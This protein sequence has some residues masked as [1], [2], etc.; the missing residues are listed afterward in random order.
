L[1]QQTKDIAFIVLISNIIFMLFYIML[2]VFM[3]IADMYMTFDFSFNIKTMFDI[4]INAIT[5]SLTY[6]TIMGTFA[7]VIM[8]SIRLF[9][10]KPNGDQSSSGVGD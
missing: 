5:I 6:T 4:F 7:L 9:Q 10:E 8:F 2:N 1:K 3:L